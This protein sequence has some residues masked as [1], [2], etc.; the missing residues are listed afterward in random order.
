MTV[1]ATDDE[2]N[3]V[4]I[5]QSDGLAKFK[6][7]EG[8]PEDRRKEHLA[9]LK[10]AA[11]RSNLPLIDMAKVR[12]CLLEATDVETGE[13]PSAVIVPDETTG[14]NL[15]VEIDFEIVD[16]EGDLEDVEGQATF[17]EDEVGG[18]AAGATGGGE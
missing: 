8:M 10:V 9:N 18:S 1:I 4:V 13:P 12:E 7:D 16:D 17:F 3:E 5:Q 6:I 2:G 15:R 11:A 14:D